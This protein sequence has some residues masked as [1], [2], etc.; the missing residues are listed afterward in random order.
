MT[1]YHDYSGILGNVVVDGSVQM[2]WKIYSLEFKRSF[3]ERFVKYL[4][5][6]VNQYSCCCSIESGGLWVR[7]PASPNLAP[8]LFKG[9]FSII[10]R[11]MDTFIDMT[12]L[13]RVDLCKKS[14]D[15]DNCRGGRKA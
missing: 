6:I 11:P 1:Y 4:S 13:Y 9:T 5:S 12:V 7:T 3:I 10:G 15:C 8:S 2:K 14:N